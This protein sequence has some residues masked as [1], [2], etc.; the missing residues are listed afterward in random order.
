MTKTYAAKKLLEH[1]PLSFSEF[2]AIT[3]WH[4]SRANR[5]LRCLE[6]RGEVRRFHLAGCH[7]NVYR[8]SA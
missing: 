3:G 6:G 7:R 8:L 2:R 4:V 5:V 1:G